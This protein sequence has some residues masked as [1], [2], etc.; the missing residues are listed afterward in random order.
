MTF[1]NFCNA[2]ASSLDFFFRSAS[3]AACSLAM[4]SLS[5][6]CEGDGDV[7]PS[8]AGVAAVECSECTDDAED[9]TGVFSF[10]CPFIFPFGVCVSRSRSLSVPR[11]TNSLYTPSN[12]SFLLW[13]KTCHT[14]PRIA[15]GM[16]LAIARLSSSALVLATA[17]GPS[18]TTDC[19]RSQS[20]GAAGSL[21]AEGPAE[22]PDAV[23]GGRLG[24]VEGGCGEDGE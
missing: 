11:T 14:T 24:L 6:S 19:H 1:S 21:I 20:T 5:F 10:A 3:I 7:M 18:Y 2:T 16:P 22:T 23:P 15:L 12:S 17:A 4:L 13:A 9:A 8:V